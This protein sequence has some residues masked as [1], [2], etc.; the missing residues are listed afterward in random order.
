MKEL[1]IMNDIFNPVMFLYKPE[2]KWD[3][4]SKQQRKTNNYL[5][6]CYHHLNYYEGTDSLCSTCIRKH[7]TDDIYYI[8][9]C[10]KQRKSKLLKQ[11]VP[12]IRLIRFKVSRKS[13]PL[14]SPN[15][16]CPIRDHGQHCAYFKCL[17]MLQMYIN[18]K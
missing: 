9:D 12:E 16:T 4:L 1:C 18:T 11:I 6:A 2:C 13:L 14:I 15:I 7:L 3:N 5:T 8:I 10:D 17:S